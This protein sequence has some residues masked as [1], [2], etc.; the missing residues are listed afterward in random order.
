[1]SEA[2]RGAD[3]WEDFYAHGSRWSGNANE[4][5]VAEV[6]GMAPGHALDLGCGEGGDAIWLAQQG[7]R[8]TAV[9]I[10]ASALTAASRNAD[11]AGVG[12]TIT[13]D[14]HDLEETWPAGPFDLVV[15]CY[16]HSNLPLERERI[17]RAAATLV[18]PGGTLL[19][20]SHAGSPS[21]ADGQGHGHDQGHGH[22]GRFPT[23]AEVAD[24]LVLG[25]DWV[26]ERAADVT[27]SGTAPDGSPGTRR[28][29]VVRARRT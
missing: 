21:W 14:R 26:V 23:A 16:L 11:A 3:F 9:D 6:D 4:L 27:R 24:A 22:A 7:W 28:D 19:I 12:A 1:M 17:L 10:A 13:W 8:V 20:V 2:Q 29:S 5:L 15:S 25:D 18:G